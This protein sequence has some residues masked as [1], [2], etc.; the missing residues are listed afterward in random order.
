MQETQTSTRP[1]HVSRRRISKV[2]VTDENGHRSVFEGHG[3]MST[4]NPNRH[5]EPSEVVLD[6][7]MKV[8][9]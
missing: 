2:E 1:T 3:S 7:S 5:N 4:Y 8:E 9:R 6:I